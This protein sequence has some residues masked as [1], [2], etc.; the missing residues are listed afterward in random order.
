MSQLLCRRMRSSI[1]MVQLVLKGMERRGPI[2]PPILGQLGAD[3]HARKR[4]PSAR[5]GAC[6]M[7]WFDWAH[8]AL[9][10]V[11]GG[12]AA[13]VRGGW[14]SPSEPVGCDPRQGRRNGARDQRRAT[15]GS[16]DVRGPLVESLPSRSC[17]PP[18]VSRRPVSLAGQ[19]VSGRTPSAPGGRRRSGMGRAPPRAACGTGG[20]RCGD[21]R[22]V[23]CRYTPRAGSPEPS[24]GAF[25]VQ[26][27]RILTVRRGGVCYICCVRKNLAAVHRPH[28]P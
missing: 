21:A 17:R 19:G 28:R 10:A 11:E 26:A 4:V 7:P 16:G 3:C 15:R 8:H 18:T 22:D 9:S 25:S 1:V 12:G 20:I 13:A 23:S 27:V 2:E 14:R 5:G 6:P 24:V